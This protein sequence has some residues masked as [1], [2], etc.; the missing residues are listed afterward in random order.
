MFT[1]KELA[2]FFFM[3]RTDRKSIYTQISELVKTAQEVAEQELNQRRERLRTMLEQEDKIYEEEFANKVKSRIDEDI[4]HR[5]DALF[6]IK[7]E[8]KRLEKEFLERKTIQQQFESCYEIREALR[9]KETLQTKEVQLEQIVEKERAQLRERQLDDY[10]C[11]V[12]DA[13]TQRYDERQAFETKKKCDIKRSMRC[14]LEQQMEMHKRD[15]ERQRE[16]KRAEAMELNKVME[17][18]RLENFDR[19]RLGLPKKTLAYREELLGMIA[20]NKAKRDAEECERIEEH[21]QLMRDVAREQQEYSA[22]VLQRKRAVYNAT[23][24]YLDYA[25]RMRKLEEDTQ[26]MRD[27]RI[28]DLRHVDICTKSNIQRELQRKAEIAALCYAELR[29][30]ICEEYERRLRDIQ[31]LREPKIIENRF[32]RPEKTRAD[33]MAERR[34][35]R[36]G[37]DEQLI[38]NARVHAEEEAKYNADLKLA[39]NDPEFCTELAEKYL[40]AGID[41]LPPHANWLIYACPQKQFVAKRNAPAAAGER[42][43]DTNTACLRPCGCAARTGLECTHHNWSAHKRG[44]NAD[45]KRRL[46]LESC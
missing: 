21:R 32:A 10:W 30:Q 19:L 42:E 34:K 6:N 2:K 20:E 43:E 37:L 13:R 7:E 25:R 14:V 36:A 44:A 26:N 8:R 35:M 16:H 29:R 11:K 45:A 15:E 41:Y 17:E 38:E 28:D 27:A 5:K 3:K 33:I 1:Q 31:E 39:I 9:R 46:E 24:E 22:A 40:S 12:R 23:M 18:I 4:Q